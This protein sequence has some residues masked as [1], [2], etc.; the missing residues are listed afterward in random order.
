[1]LKNIISVWKDELKSG[2]FKI[3]AIS[4]PLSVVISMIIFTRFLN[5]IELRP[6]IVMFDPVLAMFNPIDISWFTFFLMYGA[7]IVGLS[8]LLPYPKAFVLALL[9]Y[10]VMIWVRMPAMYTTPFEPPATILPLID[11]MVSE[12]G[13]GTLMTK[14][15]FF[16]GHT[17]TVFLLFLNSQTKLWKNVFLVLTILVGFCVLI[18][19]VHY[20]VDVIAAPFFGY[21]AY[22]I[23]KGFIK[24]IY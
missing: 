1:M 22:V 8:S 9:S 20:T 14:D 15:L 17:A 3:L 18:Q 7:L 16:S 23:A 11:P 24:R 2:K 19:H 21:G 12:I 4:A 6:G 5:F 10:T 13:V